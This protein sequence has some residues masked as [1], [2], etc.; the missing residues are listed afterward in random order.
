AGGERAMLGFENLTWAPIDRSLIEVSL[1]T[2]DERAYMDAY[3]A[4]VLELVG[5]R[6]P[7]DVRTWLETVCAPL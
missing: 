7:S 5:P 1:L 3:H 2:P 6:V 4:K